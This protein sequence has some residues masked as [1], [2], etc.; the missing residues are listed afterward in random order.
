[1][2]H[3]QKS[4]G[5]IPL[6]LSPFAG[7]R[8]WG[9]RCGCRCEGWRR[10]DRQALAPS[11]PSWATLPDMDSITLHSYC[12]RQMSSFSVKPPQL[13]SF[14][15]GQLNAVLC[16]TEL[17]NPSHFHRAIP[18]PFSQGSWARGRPQKASTVA[19]APDLNQGR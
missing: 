16:Y 2:G 10:R 4:A 19:G 6:L 14:C 17:G 11:W 18:S 3:N 7:M 5:M 1:M 9:W 13:L 12:L 15:Y 8:A